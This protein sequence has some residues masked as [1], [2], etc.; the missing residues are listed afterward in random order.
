MQPASLRTHTR[1]RFSRAQRW[2][3]ELLFLSALITGAL[4]LRLVG[5]N[6]DEFQHLHPDERFLTMVTSAISSPSGWSEYFDTESSPLNPFNR[7]YKFFVY[8]TAP[9]FAV[10]YIGEALAGISVALGGVPDWMHL[11]ATLNLGTGYDEVHLLGRIV[12]ACAEL[13]SCD[14]YGRRSLR[15]WA[16]NC[17]WLRARLG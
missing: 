2:A 10:R 14:K 4:F 3:F 16:R 17:A 6:W 13:I 15:C 5:L 7:D 1:L 9:I 8:G 12:S 11:P